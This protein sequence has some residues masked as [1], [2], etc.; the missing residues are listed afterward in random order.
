M[1]MPVNGQS[2]F[3]HKKFI[4]FKLT[5]DVDLYRKLDLK[6]LIEYNIRGFFLYILLCHGVFSKWPINKYL[7]ITRKNDQ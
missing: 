6:A 7:Q 1:N 3:T 2:K 5:A 4:E